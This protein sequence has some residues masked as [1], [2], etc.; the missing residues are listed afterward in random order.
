MASPVRLSH[1]AQVVPP[2]FRNFGLSGSECEFFSCYIFLHGNSGGN[3]FHRAC[4][5]SCDWVCKRSPCACSLI[6]SFRMVAGY[7]IKIS[8]LR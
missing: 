4:S 1:G 2:A 3:G 7:K 6:V 5:S 8:V